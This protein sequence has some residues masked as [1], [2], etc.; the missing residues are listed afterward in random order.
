MNKRDIDYKYKS[1]I[2]IK[3]EQ[4]VSLLRDETVFYEKDI[5]LLKQIY[6]QDFHSCSCYDLSI[7]NKNSPQ[8]YSSPVAALGKRILN[9]LRKE[10]E[11]RENGQNWC[12]IVLFLGGQG[13]HFEWKIRPELQKA[14]EIVFPKLQSLFDE[15]LDYFLNKEIIE[16][17]LKYISNAKYSNIKPE[18][19]V[20]ITI[21][22]K[23]SYKRNKIVAER[24]LSIA[25]FRC[26]IDNN[27]STFK[28]KIDDLP[29]VE[30][31]HLI[32]LSFQSDFEF[33]LDVEE[34]IVSLCSNCHNEIHYGKNAK[35][36][37]EFLYNKRKNLLKNK[38]I[39]VTLEQLYKY[40]GY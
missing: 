32:P 34:N 23:T 14:L 28:R 37:I 3:T 4:W 31:H 27:H 36:L 18:K 33:S 12:Y 20:P 2:E 35:E 13:E 16:K 1:N 5:Q 10:P 15:D 40:Y 21:S 39:D 8:S 7:I 24:A 22:G 26:E 11:K 25:E 9:K 29:Y 6:K 38:E 19:P 17:K 30:A